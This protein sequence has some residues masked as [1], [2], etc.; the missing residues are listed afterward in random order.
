MIPIIFGQFL[1]F[2]DFANKWYI[3]LIPVINVFKTLRDALS[4]QMDWQIF[5]LTM[6]SMSALALGALY[7]SARMFRRESVLFRV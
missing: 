3:G 5:G 4:Q 6:G 2:F 1:A 7:I